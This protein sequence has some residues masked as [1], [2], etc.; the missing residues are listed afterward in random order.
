MLTPEQQS[1]VAMVKNNSVSILTG[2]PGVGKTFTCKQIIQEFR[3]AKQTVLLA[4]PSG[5]AAKRLSEATGRIASTIHR[6][7]EA[8]MRNGTFYFNCNETNPLDA[9]LVILDEVSMVSNGLMCDFLKA[10]TKG[11]KILFVGDQYQLPSVGPGAVLRDFLASGKIPHVELTEIHRNA[12]DIV[13]ACHKIKDGKFY[14]PSPKLDLERGMNLRHVEAK[15]PVQIKNIIQELVIKRLPARGYNPVWDVQVLSPT[16]KMSDISCK[17]LN[18]M[19]QQ[20]LNPKPPVNGTIFRIGDK[21]IQTKNESIN[22]DYVVNGDLGTIVDIKAKHLT[23]SFYNPDRKV[24]ISRKSNN[25][26]LAYAITGHRFQGSEAPVIIIPVHRT[27]SYI[28]NRPWIYTAISRA[29]QIC[30][31]VGQFDA[32]RQAIRKEGANLRLTKL[33][34]KLEGY[35]SNCN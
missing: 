34:E 24:E 19:L 33:R 14:E 28:L 26:L 17:S 3:D 25:L 29:R 5:K 15:N 6:L 1:A 23:V 2:A 7:L 10:V 32:I 35:E 13:Y 16:N 9:D 31:T 8:E 30:I 22:G 27:L 12:G 4:A 20:Q 18:T 21:V 11:T